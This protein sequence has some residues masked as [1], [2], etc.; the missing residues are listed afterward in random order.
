[1]LSVILETVREQNSCSGLKLY[2]FLCKQSI[3]Q[4]NNKIGT[5]GVE[6]L[7]KAELHNLTV[8]DLGR[9]CLI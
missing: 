8:L 4:E 2:L 6:L 5:K 3:N 7:I 9:Y 1:M